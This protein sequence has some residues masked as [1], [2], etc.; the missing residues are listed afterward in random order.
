MGG[1]VAVLD[2]DGDG[3]PDLLFIGS[4]WPGD[5]RAKE[6]K[7]S[8]ALYRNE[9][10]GPDGLPRFRETT[11]EAGLERV[12]YGMGAAAGDFDNDGREDVYVTA[13]GRNYL[14]HNSGGRFEEVAAKSASPTPAG[15]LPRLVRL[16]RRR[17]PRPSSCAVTWTGRRRG[18]SS[19]R[20]TE[21]R[22]LL[23]PALPG[24]SSTSRNLGG[25][26]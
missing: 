20:W 17:P 21:R 18:A 24:T 26:S 13:L 3:R 11:R 2:Y 10:N 12:F 1:G 25:G 14:F 8:L 5:P 22:V 15:G 4:F 23:H 19:A 16:R 6:Q 7:S 9:G